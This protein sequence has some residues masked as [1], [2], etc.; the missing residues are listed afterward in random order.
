MSE[1]EFEKLHQGDVMGCSITSPLWSIRFSSVGTLVTDVGEI[2]CHP[3][4]IARECRVPA[5]VAVGNAT[6]LLQRS[7]GGDRANAIA[8]LH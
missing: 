2:L 6:G 4:I 7:G 3:A 8:L 1:A 5:V